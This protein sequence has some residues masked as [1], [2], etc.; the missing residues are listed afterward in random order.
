[1]RSKRPGRKLNQSYEDA[2]MCPIWKQFINPHKLRENFLDY[3]K[4]LWCEIE[5]GDKTLPT[6]T[7][8]ESH[9]YAVDCFA[10][11]I[12]SIVFCDWEQSS[13]ATMKTLK[14]AFDNVRT[15]HSIIHTDINPLVNP[16]ISFYDMLFSSTG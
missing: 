9:D 7:Q 12:Y 16:S 15:N 1:M 14:V 11:A 6:V 5:A 4:E 8:S 2:S 3:L 13:P 10:K